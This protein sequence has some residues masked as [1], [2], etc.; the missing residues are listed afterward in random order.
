MQ[1]THVGGNGG[2]GSGGGGSGGGELSRSGLS[3]IRSAPATWIETLLD[4]DEED[5]L[6]PN[7]CLTEL[8]TGNSA[9]ITSRDSFEFPSPVEQGLYNHQAGFHRQNSSPADFLSGS[10][11]GTDGFFSNFGI[12]ANYDYLS[13]NVDIPP[14]S[15]RSREMEAHFSSQMVRI[16]SNHYTTTSALNLI[17]L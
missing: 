9:G 4:D 7:L 13:T 2:G 11:A 8:L 17:E 15:K 16:S 10:G 3:R 6:K 1:S 12:P 14:A 5:G